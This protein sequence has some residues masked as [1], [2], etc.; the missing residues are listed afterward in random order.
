MKTTTQ[1]IRS[2][3]KSISEAVDA[4]GMDLSFNP[5]EAKRSLAIAEKG[6]GKAFVMESGDVYY[7]FHCDITVFNK[8]TPFSACISNSPFQVVKIDEDAKEVLICY[9]NL[10]KSQSTRKVAAKNDLILTCE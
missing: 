10:P 7:L 8:F 1:K 6:N 4:S 2:I 5:S 9:L 3:H